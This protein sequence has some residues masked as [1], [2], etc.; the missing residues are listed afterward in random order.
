[1]ARYTQA[2]CRLCRREGTKLFIKGSRCFSEKCA[3]SRRQQA[4]GVHGTSRRRLSD[5]GIGL[6]AKQKAKRVYGILEKQCHNYFVKASAASGNVGESFL[7]L[8]ETRLDNIIY[9]LGMAASRNQARQYIRYGKILVDGKLV[10]SPS[11][12]V[13]PGR[14]ISFSNKEQAL[15]RDVEVPEWL[16]WNTSEKFGQ[17]KTYPKREQL[18]QDINEQL[19]IEHY[20]R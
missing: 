5:Y 1:M 4:P 11:Y 16:L 10:K 6:R 14:K 15:A 7:V 9:S 3:L 20:S 13:S 12:S 19:I 2:K 8:L 17:I 18:N